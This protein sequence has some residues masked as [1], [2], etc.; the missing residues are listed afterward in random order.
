M[1]RIEVGNIL[2]K[3]GGV[4]KA[5]GDKNA[6]DAPSEKVEKQRKAWVLRP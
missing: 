4:N 2:F 6:Q 3:F 5:K 1:M